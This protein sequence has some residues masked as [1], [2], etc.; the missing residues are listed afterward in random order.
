MALITHKVVW[1]DTLWDLG[2]KYGV[3]YME[4]ARINNISNP[5]LI[6]VGQ[7]LKIKDDGG[8]TVKPDPIPPSTTYYVTIQAF[9]V[10]ADTERKLFATW[11]F[12]RSNTKNYSVL[13]EYD[14]GD[15]VWFI[16]R[17]G[18][19]E[20]QQTIYDAPSNAKKVRVKIKPNSETKTVNGT[21]TNYW[22]GGWCT[23]KEY[24]FKDAPPKPDKPSTPSVEVD[25]Y[26]LTATLTNLSEQSGKKVQFQIVVNDSTIFASGTVDIITSKAVYSKIIEAGNKYKVR[27]RTVIGK[28]YSEWTDYSNNYNSIPSPPNSIT[29]CRGTSATSIFLAWTGVPSAE[30]YDIEYTNEVKYFE[31]SDQVQS[32][33]GVTATSYEKTGLESGKQYFFR[34]RASNSQGKSDWSGI[35]SVVIGKDP[36][37]PTTWSSST[38]VVSGEELFLY[39]VHNTEDGSNLTYSDLEIIVGGVKQTHKIKN[40]SSEN[41]TVEFKV[42]TSSY[43]EGTK[44]QWRVRTSGVTMTFGEWSIQRVIDVYAP[45]TLTLTL[46]DIDN[47][48]ISE[49][50]SFPLVVSGIA[51]P[52]TQVPTGY[53]LSVIANGSYD[54]SDEIGNYKRVNEGD[55]VYSKYFDISTMLNTKISASDIDLENNIE[56]TV[57]CVVSMNSGLTAE[58]DALLTVAWTDKLYQPNAE[59][60]VNKEDVTAQIR[61]FCL[62]ENNLPVEGVTLSVYRREFDGSFTEIGS[63]LINGNNTFV[64]DPHPSLDYARYR[65]VATT[66]DTGAVSYYDVPGYPVGDKNIIIQ[67]A[68]TWSEFD[69]TLSDQ[70]SRPAWS[71]SM[72]KLPYNVDVSDNTDV[73]VEMVQYIGRKRPVSYYGTQINQTSTWNADILKSD[74]ELLYA[75]RRLAVWTGDVYVR[76]PSGSGY[77]ASINVSFNQK[78]K[79]LT[80]PVTF[81]ITRVEGGI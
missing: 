59:V 6:Y 69:S 10:Q 31:S 55:E 4:I 65:I 18:T 27:A 56:Y 57:R 76:E 41:K 66:D 7:V 60:G 75:I 70:L 77:W 71:G 74:K 51:G 8:G 16:G 47:N 64:I 48:N 28:E 17:D 73:D 44:I 13:W 53:H 68:E 25:K 45:P 37:A 52:K 9:G 5:S 58:A 3:P 63:G 54:T 24:S 2:I 36:G 14:T 19:E 22:T 38:T 20:Y 81:N 29:Q 30:N 46:R 62:D 39:W 15:G 72:I 12:S 42:D 40:E 61:P 35:K 50:T 49:L 11:S 80:I 33:T 78:H 32:I 1:G 79:E 67:W 23:Y 43:V 34:V 26:K 21:E